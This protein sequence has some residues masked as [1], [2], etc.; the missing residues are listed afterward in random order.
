LF[1][2]IKKEKLDPED[3]D[4]G[5]VHQQVINF[6]FIIY[7]YF[8]FMWSVFYTLCNLARLG[9]M[10]AKIPEGMN[11]KFGRLFKAHFQVAVIFFLCF[12]YKI[13]TLQ[14]CCLCYLKLSPKKSNLNRAFYSFGADLKVGLWG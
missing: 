3:L 8:N 2:K 1:V 6:V 12:R 4:Y 5:E 13:E 9:S 7:F 11:P 10:S 14:D